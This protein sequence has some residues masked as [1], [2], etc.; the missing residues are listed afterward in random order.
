[1]KFKL[2]FLGMFA[3]AAMISCNNDVIG[4]SDD[5]PTSVPEGIPVYASINFVVDNGLG[6]Y[7]GESEEPGIGDELLINNGAMYVYKANMEPQAAAYIASFTGTGDR[8]ITL[9]ATSGVKK[10]FVAANIAQSTG[11]LVSIS[12]TNFATPFTTLNNPLYST[13]ATA[14]NTTKGTVGITTKAD[15]LI[16]GLAKGETYGTATASYSG[17]NNMLMTNWDGPDD[18]ATAGPGLTYINKAT[19]EFKLYPDVDSLKSHNHSGVGAGAD[20]VNHFNINVQRAFAKVSVELATTL[21]TVTFTPLANHSNLTYVAGDSAQGNIGVFQPW[22]GVTAGGGTPIWSLGNIP[23][24][25]LPFQMFISDIVRDLNYDAKD[26]SIRNHFA[27]WVTRYD[28]TRVFP[29]TMTSYPDF[30]NITTPAVRNVMCTSTP[31]LNYTQVTTGTGA[32]TKF[33]YTIENARLNAVTHDYGTFIVI[34]GRYTPSKVI[35]NIVRAAVTSNSPLVYINN[36]TDHTVPGLDYSVSLTADN[37]TLFYIP[38]EKVFIKGRDNL[39]AFYAWVKGVQPGA[40]PTDFHGNGIVPFDTDVF[41]AVNNGLLYPNPK[42]YAYAGGQCWYRVF[43]R[44][45]KAKAEDVNAVRRNHI[46]AVQI[47]KIKGPGIANPNYI[48]IP[49]EPIE[50]LDTYVTANIKTLPWHKVEQVTDVDIN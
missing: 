19:C 49:D 41:S 16:V 32:D 30:V 21:S 9:K 48:L 27:K 43:L 4:G 15:G 29:T 8:K 50:E 7:A 13:S 11:N 22:S 6:T 17:S 20:S 46:Y 37:D 42:I 38:T 35:T 14:W 26:D 23:K 33:A 36:S 1:M 44:D 18:V 25:T 10:I 40:D 5:D 24:E 39:L 12:T 31:T 34:G 47:Q 28:N 45:G 2:F 3:A